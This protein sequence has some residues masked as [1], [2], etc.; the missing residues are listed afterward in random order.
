MPETSPTVSIIIKALNEERHIA[1]AIESALAALA[2]IGGE[3]I[4]ADSGSSDRTIEIARRYPIK[5]VQLTNREE[6]SC[7]IGAQLGFQYSRGRFLC[8]IDGDMRLHGDFL[9]AALA[10]LN[11]NATLAGVGGL[12][13]EREIANMEF[14]QRNKRRDPDR[15]AGPVTRLNGCGVYR[16]SAIESIGHLTDRN[17]HGAEEL[18][19]SAR[20][21]ARGWTLARLDRPAVDHYGH[22]SNA[23]RL[24]LRRIVTRNSFATGELVRAAI[25][26]PHFWFAVSNDH[27]CRLFLLVAIWWGAIAAVP[28]VWSGRTALL[29]IATVVLWPIAA[30]SLRWRSV[31]LGLYSIAAWTV[32][33]LSFLPGFLRSRVSPTGWIDSRVLADVAPAEQRRRR[34]PPGRVANLQPA[35]LE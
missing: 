15:R 32:Y 34:E 28:F 25:G 8:L 19:L 16:R 30:M 1:G 23:Y 2:E 35:R 10:L 26:R 4:L 29:A 5:I 12:V 22:T 20:L 14:E 31:R 27:G 18:D 7:G 17:L 3:V 24:L 13:V 9:P 21:H 11:E 33:A 6:R